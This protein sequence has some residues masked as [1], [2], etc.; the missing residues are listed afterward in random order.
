MKH[1]YLYG[2]L[3]ETVYMKQPAGIA[4]NVKNVVCHLRKSLYGLKQAARVWNIMFH[5]ALKKMRFTQSKNDSSFY[6]RET[7]ENTVYLAVYVDDIVVAC[8][9]EKEYS[10]FIKGLNKHFAVT[11]AI[12][13]E[14]E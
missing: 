7:G 14:L 3:Q 12:S 6:Y 9:T 13:L 4:S 8:R 1:A 5:A 11:F 10:R 2:E